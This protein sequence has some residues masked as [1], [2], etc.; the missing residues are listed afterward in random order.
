MKSNVV[1]SSQWFLKITSNQDAALG[2][3]AE[4]ELAAAEAW[5]GNGEREGEGEEDKRRRLGTACGPMAG[6]GGRL[7]VCLSDA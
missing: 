4:A 2:T 7:R 1:P 5:E 6:G 3:E